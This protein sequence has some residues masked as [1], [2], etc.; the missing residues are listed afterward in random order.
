MSKSK[1]TRLKLFQIATPCHEDW[2]KMEG[3][4]QK[5]FCAGCGCF[6]NNLAAMSATE[7]EELLSSTE[8]V[9]TRATFDTK[10]GVLTRDGWIPRLVLAGA[11]AAIAAGCNTTTGESG[12]PP[13]TVQE[14]QKSATAGK[15]ADVLMG[16]PAPE[17][18]TT[19]VTMGDFS[20]CQDPERLKKKIEELQLIKRPSVVLD[21]DL[22]PTSPDA[23]NETI[24]VGMMLVPPDLPD[25]EAIKKK[26][27]KKAP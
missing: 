25:K 3:D 2:D 15:D 17:P 4:D 13:S 9:C 1:L 26:P 11:I 23:S 16:T 14:G 22:S 27:T 10:R 6:V 5:R 7:A 24:A 20:S 18:S 12:P 19:H 8:R 21:D